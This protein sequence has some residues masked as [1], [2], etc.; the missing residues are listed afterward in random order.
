MVEVVVE[1]I[2]DKSFRKKQRLRSR[3]LAE[4][5]VKV[6]MEYLI[7]RPKKLMINPLI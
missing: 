4:V 1:E 7:D 6:P 3:H 5:E 2:D